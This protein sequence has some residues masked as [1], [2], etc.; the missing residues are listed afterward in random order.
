M[1]MI[2][3]SVVIYSAVTYIFKGNMIEFTI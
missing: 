1:E 3:I 2:V